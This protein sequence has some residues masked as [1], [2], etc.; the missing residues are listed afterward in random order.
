MELLALS[1][2]ID[3]TLRGN[4]RRGL[5]TDS[6]M[7]HIIA[8]FLVETSPSPRQTPN[9]NM[10][11]AVTISFAERSNIENK[12]KIPLQENLFPIIFSPYPMPEWCVNYNTSSRSQPL[13]LRYFK[14]FRGCGLFSSLY[15][16][17]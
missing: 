10:L 7:S 8:N 6:G 3:E 5:A 9:E 2:Q 15:L 12:S 11:I 14:S 1:L 13:G 17:A 4:V 16:E